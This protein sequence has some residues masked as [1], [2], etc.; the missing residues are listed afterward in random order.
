[1]I[2]AVEW[3]STSTKEFDNN[4]NNNNNGA[5]DDDK[6]D[7]KFNEMQN[8][9]N[10]YIRLLN[11]YE[12][13]EEAKMQLIKDKCFKLN[14]FKIPLMGTSIHR[15][16][17]KCLNNLTLIRPHKEQLWPSYMGLFADGIAN[18]VKY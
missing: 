15:K 1:M 11:D 13:E 9:I 16:R 5:V 14:D 8:C 4:N 12:Q 2:F 10:G 7:F 17:L 3:L 6:P 18:I